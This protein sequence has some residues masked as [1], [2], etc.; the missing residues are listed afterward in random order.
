MFLYGLALS[1]ICVIVYKNFF[2]AVILG[3]VGGILFSG[4]LTLLVIINSR[5][6]RSF[7][8][9]IE[10]ENTIIFEGSA[11]HQ[12][13]KYS[14]GGW[15]FLTEESL[16]FIPHK[17]NFN[18]S[19][20]IISSKDM[21]NVHKSPN[22]IKGIDILCKNERI[23]TFIVNERKRWVHILSEMIQKQKL[24]IDDHDIEQKRVE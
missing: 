9:E 22:K 14:N 16:L 20:V 23:E 12:E 5:K 10:K 6:M 17:I 3:C 15:I 1:V 2:K 4:A 24:L 18:T 8:E 11:N 7:R 13:G 19:K 21:C